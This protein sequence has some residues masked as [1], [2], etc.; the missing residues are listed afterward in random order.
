MDFHFRLSDSKSL[1]VFRT[2]LSILTDLQN[3]LVWMVYTRPLIS[4]SSRHSIKHLVTVPIDQ[5]T[6]G[7]AVTFMFI[8]FL[9]SLARSRYLSLFSLSFSFT[10]WSAGT[11]KFTV[12]YVLFF[13]LIIAN[14]GRLAEIIWSVCISKSLRILG[15]SFSKTDSV[16]IP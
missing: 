14:S 11:A 12:L 8:V 2:L 1:Q 6:I 9:S 13:W 4:K 3:V 16:N 5:D 15:I 7:I 10:L